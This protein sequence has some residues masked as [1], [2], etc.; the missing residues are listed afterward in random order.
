MWGF[1]GGIDEAGRGPL[2]GPV[3]L[4]MVVAPKGFRFYHPELGK[5]RDSKKLT[6]KRREIWHK[7]LTTHPKLSYVRT[8][9]HPRVI[10]R[11][12]IAKAAHRGALRLVLR[13]ETRP[14]F[15]YLDGA[16]SL[17]PEILHKVVIRGDDR[18]PIVAAASI[19][20]KV[21]RDRYMT[22]LA[23]KFPKYR[24]DAHKGYGTRVH[25]K[26]IKKYGPSPFHRESFI[27]SFV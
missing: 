17:P 9:V 13:S 1:I 12:N 7:F 10:D 27:S 22:R 4:A 23:K 26:A 14:H 8:Y 5:I 3:S 25:I 21:A 6:P 11:I 16:L 20:A 19:I 18:I 15:V 24:F 2:A